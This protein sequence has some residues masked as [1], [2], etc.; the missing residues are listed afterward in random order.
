MRDF[1]YESKSRPDLDFS[2]HAQ[3]TATRVNQYLP[4]H[5]LE[6]ADGVKTV[7]HLGSKALTRFHFHG[8][9]LSAPAE[10]E[11]DFGAGLPERGPVEDLIEDLGFFAMRPKKMEDP[12]LQ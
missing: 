8:Q 2:R 1:L 3:R 6:S 11:I 9:E 4:D 7:A 12:A 10:Q 5:I